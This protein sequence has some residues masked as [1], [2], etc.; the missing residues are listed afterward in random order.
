VKTGDKQSL[1]IDAS[2]SSETSVDLQWTTRSHI[3]EYRTLQKLYNSFS[4]LHVIYPT[5][6]RAKGTEPIA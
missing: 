4:S 1:D 5:P 2:H 3:P 6:M